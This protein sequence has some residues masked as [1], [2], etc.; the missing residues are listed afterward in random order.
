MEWLVCL[1][2][3]KMRKSYLVKNLA[4][5]DSTF[6]LF[7][8]K[9]PEILIRTLQTRKFHEIPVCQTTDGWTFGADS[10]SSGETPTRAPRRHCASALFSASFVT[11]S[12]Y[13]YN[14]FLKQACSLSQRN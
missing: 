6:Q 7:F 9:T 3:P 1:H 5:F 11:I 2:H 14:V 12:Y 8:R 4:I 10:T 13:T